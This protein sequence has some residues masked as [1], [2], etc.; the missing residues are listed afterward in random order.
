M[1]YDAEIVSKIPIE[2]LKEYVETNRDDD[3]V[4]YRKGKRT[5]QIVHNNKFRKFKAPDMEILAES[6]D[7]SKD[8][9][10]NGYYAVKYKNQQE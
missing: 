1:T 9:L 3:F 8:N 5:L 4:Y 7:I 6:L 10:I 2:F